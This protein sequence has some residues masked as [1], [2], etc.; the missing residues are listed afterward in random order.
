[1][2]A[3]TKHEL[4]AQFR[5]DWEKHYKVSNLIARGYQRRLCKQCGRYFWSMAERDTCADSSCVGYE[6]IGRPP[7]KKPLDYV[8]A[9]KKVESYFVKS[10]HT[11]LKPYPTVARWRDD[12]YFTIA[13]IN[14]FQPYVVNG[15]LEPP[16]NPLIVPQPCIRFSDITNV[17]VTG[18]HYTSFVMIGQHAFNTK[19]TGD[20]YWKN[21]AIS[22]DINCLLNLGIHEEEITFLE[23][24]WLGGGNFGPCIEYFARGLELGNCVFMQYKITKDGAKEL[25][26]KVIDMGAGL[27]R[28]AWI[29]HGSPT[30]YE[31]VFGPAIKRMKEASGVSIDEKLFL[32]YA[33][34]SGRLNVDEAKDINEERLIIA[35][36]LGTTPEELFGALEPL[37]SLYASC[38]HLKT[39]LFTVT[40]GMLPSNSGGGY[41]LRMC[42]RRVFGFN[43]EFGL[44]MDYAKAVE[45]HAEY[46]KDIFPHLQEGVGTTIDVIAEEEKKYKAT[47]EK[48]KAKVTS[49]VL[50]A[51]KENKRITHK[52]L[53]TLYESDGIPI[54]MVEEISRQSHYPLE[55]PADFYGSLRKSD[56]VEQQ[57]EKAAYDLVH[58]PKTE[59]LFYEPV[60]EFNAKVLGTKD[61]FVI[62]DRTAFYPESGGQVNDTGMLLDER[63]THVK[64]EAG[65]ILHEVANIAKFQKGMLIKGK[66]NQERRL[67]I[68]RHHTAVHI[69]NA[70]CRAVLGN[71]IWQAGSYKDDQKAHLDVTHYRRIT[72]AEINRIENLVNEYVMQNLPVKTEVLGRNEA[73]KRYGF[74]L[75]QGGAVPGKELRVVSVGNIDHEACGGTHYMLRHTGEIGMVKIVKREGIQDG[76]ERI[77]FKAGS[78]A[79][80]YMQERE[81]LLREAAGT[82][83]VPETQLSLTIVRFFNEW[84]DRGK[85][86]EKLVSEMADSEITAVL[87]KSAKDKGKPVVRFFDVDSD[88][89]KKIAVKVTQADSPGAAILYNSEK[90][91]ICACGRKSFHSAQELLSKLIDR[92]GGVG[93]GSQQIAMGKLK[94]PNVHVLMTE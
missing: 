50:R 85:R 7:A 1:M 8:E 40:D 53:A 2:A 4:R 54:E 77:T 3:I 37:Q 62:L 82:L 72:D 81:A 90:L 89:L 31:I 83:S 44:N 65:I 41:N 67:H 51:K 55:I 68:T 56:E 46:L 75:Y 5:K 13:S 30:S 10:G 38:D 15:E 21:E 58:F 63:V 36:L 23:D 26:N 66:I 47:Q 22:H 42:M 84:K 94:M 29:T 80:A 92:Y 35:N 69:L 18:R 73:E 88:T 61:N 64:R 93:G 25:E 87:D 71:H 17:G 12:L 27:E 49:L 76:V 57:E 45:G 33:K 74:R 34:L 20:F 91:V 52:D 43:H 70:A 14:D 11:S 28:F 60:F 79:V 78:V 39:L 59:A 48:G 32:E 24:V 19:A 16:A 9:W 86:I 6:F